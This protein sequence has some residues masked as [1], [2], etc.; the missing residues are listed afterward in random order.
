LSEK[1]HFL[2]L[3]HIDSLKMNKNEIAAA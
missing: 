2:L 3:Q 1:D